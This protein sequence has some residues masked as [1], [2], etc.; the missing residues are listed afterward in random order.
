MVLPYGTR[1]LVV[2]DEP[3]IALMIE[4]TLADEGCKVIGPVGTVNAALAAIETNHLDGALLDINLKGVQSYAVADALAL[5]GIPFILLTG[6]G[7]SD[8]PEKYRACVVCDKPFS[9]QKLVE[10]VT[11]HFELG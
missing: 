6:Y 4:D 5:R 3:L 9:V 2:E 1:I 11:D 8:I 7:A 10:M